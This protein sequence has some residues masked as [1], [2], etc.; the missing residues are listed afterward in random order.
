MKSIAVLSSGND[1]CGIN[2][3]IRSVVRSAIGQG[4]KIYGVEWGFRGLLEDRIHPITS[5]SVSGIIGKSGCLLGSTNPKDEIDKNFHQILANLNKRS[6]DGIVVIGGQESFQKVQKLIDNGIHVI[7]IPSDLQDSIPCTEISLGVDSAVNNIM[8]CIDHIRSC[9][10]SKNRSFLIEVEGSHTGSL[11]LRS[12]IVSGCE[13]CL[14]P[15]DSISDENELKKIADV[16]DKTTKLGKTQ[17]LCIISSG[18]KP[19]IK[20][21][22]NYLSDH[23]GENDVAIRE[24]ILGYVQRGGSPSAFDRILGTEMGNKAVHALINGENESMVSWNNGKIGLVPFSML[25]NSKKDITEL[26]NAFKMT[27]SY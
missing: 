12:A 6:I 2:G 7:G 25:A 13:V 14:T 24:T 21:L 4:I 3:A 8:A 27:N 9:D 10:S 5:R 16:I 26:L 20:A 22:N 11:A 15:E 17:C 19:G 1:N 18:W 23:Y